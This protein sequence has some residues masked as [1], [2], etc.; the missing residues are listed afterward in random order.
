M[1]EPTTSPPVRIDRWLW[2]ARAYKTRPL[3]AQACDGGKVSVNGTAAKPHKLIRPG[4][5]IDMTHAGGRRQW[6]VVGVSERRGP[7]SAARILYDDLTP[8]PPPRPPDDPFV[9]RREPGSGRPTKRERRQMDRW[10]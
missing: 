10:R 9:P 1:T 4:D 2:A 7:A 8:P 6:R 5:L 3:A